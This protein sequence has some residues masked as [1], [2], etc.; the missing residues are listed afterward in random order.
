MGGSLI[1]L[2]VEQGHG[3]KALVRSR[4]KAEGLLGGLGVELVEGDMLDVPA[5]ADELRGADVLFHTAAYFREYYQRGDAA[6]M[7]E[8]INVQA[9][10]ELAWAAHKRGVGRTVFVSSSGIVG[11]KPDGSPGDEDTPPHPM[12]RGNGYFESK[13]RAEEALGELARDT[14]ADIVT[15]LPGWMFGPRDAAPT[16][17]GQFILDFLAGKLPIVLDGGTSVADARDVASATISAAEH[18]RA[19]E[20][21]VVGGRFHTIAEICGALEDVTGVPG[22]K[23]RVPYPGMMAMAGASELSGRLT[24]N[25]V[26]I[27]RGSVRSMRAGLAVDSGK[28]ER[29]LGATFRPLKETLGDE[30]AWFEKR[31]V[32]NRKDQ[33]AVSETKSANPFPTLQGYKNVNLTTFR[34][35]GEPVVTPVWYV[36]IDGKLYVRTQVDAG[37]VKRI[38]REERILLAPATL[39]GKAL[40]T[41]IEARVRILGVG[42]EE[43]TQKAMKTLASKYRSTPLVNLL[44]SRGNPHLVLEIMP[45]A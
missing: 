36:V 18:G 10:V 40:G 4:E 5:F 39:A 6:G 3:V 17:S 37:K 34:K 26:L 44:V 29:E 7:L 28:A 2:L 42:E 22:P 15:V 16:G 33:A 21:Y 8:K 27:S 20:R 35:S 1:R 24:G 38:R 12:T 9:A 43:L 23:R 11:V 30:V 25:P 31:G 19:G 14:G 41:D 32:T 13:A 45:G